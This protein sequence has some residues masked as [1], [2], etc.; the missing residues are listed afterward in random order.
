VFEGAEA[1]SA[2]SSQA[3][4]SKQ[5]TTNSNAIKKAIFFI[6]KVPFLVCYNKLE[7]VNQGIRKGRLGKE[8]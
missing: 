7:G 4:N 3:A 6:P 1:S 8:S 2:V 5:E